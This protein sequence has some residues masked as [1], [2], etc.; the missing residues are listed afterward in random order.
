VAGVT[1]PA[2]PELRAVRAPL[3]IPLLLLADSLLAQ[4][5]MPAMH[6]KQGIADMLL[7][8]MSAR[9]PDA[10]RQRDLLYI[11]VRH[12]RLFL[13]R[14]GL[15]LA[16]FPVATSSN[17]LGS[18]QDSFRT[19]TGLHRVAEKH[20][21]DVPPLG[22]LK[23]REFNGQLADPDFGGVDKDWITSRILWLEGLEPGVNKGPGLDSYDRYIYIHGTANER[24]VGTPSSRGCVRMRNADVIA[25]FTEVPVGALVVILDN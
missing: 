18:S 15:L 7:E 5:P 22:I 24:S 21:A 25:L 1:S 23:D 4:S 13:V 19:P 9:Y 16:D 6:P 20:G 3:L 12:Q 8:Y 17:G 14:D 2:Q 11:S 10:P